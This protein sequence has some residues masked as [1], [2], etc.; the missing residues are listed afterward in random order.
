MTLHLTNQIRTNL[1]RFVE[2]AVT[3]FEE[4]EERKMRDTFSIEESERRQLTKQS[5]R[6]LDSFEVVTEETREQVI[7]SLIELLRQINM[8]D[9]EIKKWQQHETDFRARVQEQ[10]DTFDANRKNFQIKFETAVEFV[11]NLDDKQ[12]PIVGVI[13]PSKAPESL[14][15]KIY[16]DLPWLSYRKENLKLRKEFQEGFERWDKGFTED[17][18]RMKKS[19]VSF[20]HEELIILINTIQQLKMK[21]SP[22]ILEVVETAEEVLGIKVDIEEETPDFDFDKLYAQF[23]NAKETRNVLELRSIAIELF[24][25]ID[26]FYEMEAE[27]I[28][29]FLEQNYF[30][31]D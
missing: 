15:R 29:D 13:S 10:L 22:L 2:R 3:S 7:E 8:V 6:L 21:S 14:I 17:I 5:E 26:E 4:N 28:S 24:P 11:R 31:R 18:A 23:D 20:I 9:E 16:E 1:E 30:S 25:D 12:I 27:E 19:F